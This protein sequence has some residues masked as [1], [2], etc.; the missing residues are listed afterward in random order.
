MD[1]ALE[2]RELCIQQLQLE[3]EF[4]S[5]KN[6]R[7]K[8]KKRCSQWN[9]ENGLRDTVDRKKHTEQEREKKK[10]HAGVGAWGLEQ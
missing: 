3:Q 1:G 10:K 6:E 2:I 5:I 7:R 8:V 4:P 9:V